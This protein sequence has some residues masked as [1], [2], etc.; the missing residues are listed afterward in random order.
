M[1]ND[2]DR[3]TIAQAF[4]D[5][6]ES[7]TRDNGEAFY[8]LKDGSPGWMSDAIRDAHDSGNIFPH[9]WIYDA[10]DTMVSQMADSDPDQWE[11]YAGEWADSAVD[12]YNADRAA[13]LASHLAFGVIV[14]EAVDEFGHSDQGIYGDIG[15]GQYCLLRNIADAL[16]QAVTAQAEG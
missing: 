6:F 8:R 10:C 14:D 1:E 5:A 9:D 13:W 15:I 4:A 11:D 7:A 3:Q 16:I 12:A 2:N